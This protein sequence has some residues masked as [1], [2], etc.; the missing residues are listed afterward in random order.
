MN[1]NQTV[2]VNHDM[3]IACY[4]LYRSE[5]VLRMTRDV[6]FHTL[7]SRGMIIQNVDGDCTTEAFSEHVNRHWI[8]FAKS[9][10]DHVRM[11]GFCP[12]LK[13]SIRA[14]KEGKKMSIPAIPAFGSYRIEIRLHPSTFQRSLHFF[15]QQSFPNVEGKETRKV[16]F[17]VS[18]MPK[19]DGTLQS[20]MVTLLHSFR[21]SRELYENALRVEWL[22]SH[23]TL[24]TQDGSKTQTTDAVTMDMF[25][26]SDAFMDREEASYL[27]TK[28]RARDWQRQQNIA[29]TLNG[30]KAKNKHIRIDPLTG[31]PLRVNHKHAWEDSIFSLPEGQVMAPSISTSTRTDL[32]DM[33][34]HRVDMICGIMGV[35]RNL[36]MNQ[37]SSSVGG[38]ANDIA[39]KMFMRTL[40]GIKE[41]LCIHMV[42][43]HHFMYGEGCKVD[44]PF[45]PL[46]NIDDLRTILDLGI[47]SREKIGTYMLATLGLPAELLD[48]QPLPQQERAGEQESAE[49]RPRKKAKREED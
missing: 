19:S 28:E 49:G 21:V 41:S 25:A 38:S 4:E 16:S 40:D 47:S 46:T 43:T 12:I 6:L 36:V 37:G 33:E 45:P 42:N 10:F 2:W 24:I 14:D 44:L 3:M 23:P 39:Y 22:R 31:A 32:L 27:K 9:V 26:D 18:S 8:P 29:M 15:P 34:R 11:F 20:K 5:P 30:K 1:R 35:P 17:L 7:F 13:Q 48:I